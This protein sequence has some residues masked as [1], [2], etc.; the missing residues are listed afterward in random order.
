M[1][2]KKHISQLQ[3]WT[4]RH[5]TILKSSIIIIVLLL[6]NHLYLYKQTASNIIHYNRIMS[7]VKI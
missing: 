1:L 4:T 5:P 6:K 7:P 3:K 2:I